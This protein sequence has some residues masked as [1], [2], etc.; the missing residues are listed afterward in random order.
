M[1]R[2][3]PLTIT[4]KHIGFTFASNCFWN[5]IWTAVQGC[6]TAKTKENGISFVL[7]FSASLCFW[8]VCSFS[9]SVGF[10][11]FLHNFHLIHLIPFDY[12]P[13]L[14]FLPC[15]LSLVRSSPVFSHF[16][17]SSFPHLYYYAIANARTFTS[18]IHLSAWICLILLSKIC[19]LA[20]FRHILSWFQL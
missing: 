9:Y 18:Y 6:N 17:V 10:S 5:S 19:L 20:T 7:S 2:S 13:L 1:A 4:M 15:L 16:H 11:S 8:C 12:N 14:L 3:I